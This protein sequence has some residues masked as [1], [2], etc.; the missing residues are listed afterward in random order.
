MGQAAVK[1][2]AGPWASLQPRRRGFN[3]DSMQR[4]HNSDNVKSH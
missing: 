3:I 4:S 1:H 2:K